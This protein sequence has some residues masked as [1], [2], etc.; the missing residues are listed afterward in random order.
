MPAK[1]ESP[2]IIGEDV[3]YN[4][5]TKWYKAEFEKMGWMLLA[6]KS[7]NI[8]KVTVYLHSLEHLK[9]DLERKLGKV[10]DVDKKEDIR[11]MLTN[12]NVLIEH[13]KKDLM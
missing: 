5:L 7:N 13:A 9:R 3:T 4:G 2:I 11:I 8:E 12:L 10:K 1:K 6:K